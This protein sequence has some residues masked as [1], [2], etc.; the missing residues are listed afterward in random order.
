ME[1]LSAVS[2][3]AAAIVR[4]PAWPACS[5][6]SSKMSDVVSAP[7]E[8]LTALM[9]TPS[10]FAV[11]LLQIGRLWKLWFRILFDNGGTYGTK[12]MIPQL[13]ICSAVIFA[14]AILIDKIRM[15]AFERPLLA[16]LRKCTGR[17]PGA[18]GS[19]GAS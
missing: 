14:S 1:S 10:L 17:Q 8:Q 7:N 9:L 16:L 5:M 19:P 18:G 13:V 15:Y 11:Y 6:T 3:P 12:L 4:I 2:L